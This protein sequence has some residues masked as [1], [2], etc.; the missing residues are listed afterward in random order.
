MNTR[1]VREYT[2]FATAALFRKWGQYR[3]GN[4]GNLDSSVKGKIW[5]EPDSYFIF[6]L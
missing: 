1:S 4:Q 6:V 2:M 3:P 5:C